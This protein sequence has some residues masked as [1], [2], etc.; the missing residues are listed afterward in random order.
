M[1][2]KTRKSVGE[3]MRQWG[4]LVKLVQGK[5]IR[6]REIEPKAD[7]T[8]RENSRAQLERIGAEG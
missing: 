6:E 4:K 8:E 5:E 7:A 1:Q 2:A 3:A